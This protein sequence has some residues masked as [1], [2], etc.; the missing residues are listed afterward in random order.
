LIS[1]Q[2]PFYFKLRAITNDFDY[3]EQYAEFISNQFDEFHPPEQTL[4]YQSSKLSLHQVNYFLD[5]KKK[6]S[7]SIA[8][9]KYL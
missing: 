3:D 2:I 9:S 1:F 4:D 8:S 7:S 5:L 6:K